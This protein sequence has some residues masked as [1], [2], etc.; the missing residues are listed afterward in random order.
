MT[1]RSRDPILPLLR[2]PLDGLNS[3]TSTHTNNN[4]KSFGGFVSNTYA[5]NASGDQLFVY[6]LTTNNELCELILRCRFSRMIELLSKEDRILGSN[7]PIE[8]IGSTSIQCLITNACDVQLNSQSYLLVSITSRL[9][10]NFNS[11]S[12]SNQNN[13][14]SGSSNSGQHKYRQWISLINPRTSTSSSLFTM[15]IGEEITTLHKI[16]SFSVCYLIRF[17]SFLFHFNF[18]IFIFILFFYF[19]FLF[20]F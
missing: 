16:T 17:F 9:D 19:Y 10:S 5:W 3:Q 11:N 15:E 13:I 12:I 6:S 1:G 14:N 2:K 20:F 18:E 8:G 7:G 4:S